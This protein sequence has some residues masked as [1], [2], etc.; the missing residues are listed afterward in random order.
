M[1]PVPTAKAWDAECHPG[2]LE[3]KFTFNG[4]VLNDKAPPTYDAYVLKQIDGIFDFPEVRLVE[5]PSTEQHGVLIPEVYYGSRTI[6]L[7]GAIRASNI[8]RARQM[9]YALKTAVLSAQSE[10]QLLIQNANYPQD[11]YIYCRGISCSATE[12]PGPGGYWIEFTIALKASDPRILGSIERSYAMNFTANTDVQ[13]AISNFPNYGNWWAYPRVRF[14]ENTGLTWSVTAPKI[15]WDSSSYLIGL[16]Y[17]GAAL[18][19][20]A[21]AWREFTTWGGV[22]LYD[23]GGVSYMDPAVNKTM[24]YPLVIP[25]SG[26][27]ASFAAYGAFITTRCTAETN[28]VRATAYW[29]DTYL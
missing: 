25:P 27:N 15:T 6:T 26:R 24:V 28:V 1:P 19:G 12:R 7:Q 5:I 10:Q 11:Y 3:A 2:G 9:L 20:G 17:N 8:A 22:Q 29:R 4:V 18:A 21:G 14:T 23:A 16:E 13:H